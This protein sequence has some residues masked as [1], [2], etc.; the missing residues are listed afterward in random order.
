VKAAE[1]FI[2]EP[3]DSILATDCVGQERWAMTRETVTSQ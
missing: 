3:F 2:A 1:L